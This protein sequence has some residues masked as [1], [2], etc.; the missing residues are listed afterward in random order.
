MR[1]LDDLGDR[2]RAFCKAFRSG[3]GQTP[4]NFFCSRALFAEIPGVFARS[5]R[6]HPATIVPENRR[7]IHL[8]LILRRDPIMAVDCNNDP[9]QSDRHN[10]RAEHAL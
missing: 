5:P 7:N 9:R 6:N 1:V 4:R 10:L 2:E 8:Y 3:K